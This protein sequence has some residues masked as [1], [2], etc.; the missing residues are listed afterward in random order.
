MLSL[1]QKLTC[2]HTWGDVDTRGYQSCTKCRKS[3]YVGFP[4][5]IH[6]WDIHDT[7][8]GKSMWHALDTKIYIMRCKH[9][10]E[11]RNFKSNS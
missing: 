4:E 11:M 1:L 5:C 3:V 2:Q 6:I 9:C 10:G 8:V 7:I